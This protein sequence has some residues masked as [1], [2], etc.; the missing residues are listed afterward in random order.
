MDIL[1]SFAPVA[2]E[3]KITFKEGGAPEFDERFVKI[4]ERV[5]QAVEQAVMSNG[6]RRRD[7]DH[8]AVHIDEL[9]RYEDSGQDALAMDAY[10]R[11]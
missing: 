9:P 2:I 1:S 11:G 7:V 6:G 3:L 10:A 5:G 8:S 4:K